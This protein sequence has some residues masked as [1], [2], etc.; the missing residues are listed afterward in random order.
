MIVTIFTFRNVDNEEGAKWSGPAH[1]VDPRLLEAGVDADVDDSE[2]QDDEKHDVFG[3]PPE[4][5][6]SSSSSLS[7]SSS[8]L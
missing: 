1:C 5:L 7:S 4:H 8:S 2:T 6:P 3:V